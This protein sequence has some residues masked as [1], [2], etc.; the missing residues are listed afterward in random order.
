MQYASSIVHGK[1][2]CKP[3]QFE[4]EA[5]TMKQKAA[6]AAGLPEFQEK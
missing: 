6:R 5:L 3:L 1:W 4:P 2:D